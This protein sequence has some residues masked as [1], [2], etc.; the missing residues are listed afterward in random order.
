MNSGFSDSFAG[1]LN[2]T[3]LFVATGTFRVT[4]K[5]VTNAMIAA[6]ANAKPL[7]RPSLMRTLAMEVVAATPFIEI[8]F[9][10]TTS[11]RSLVTPPSVTTAV[12]ASD[13]SFTRIAV[14]LFPPAM[15]AAD[16]AAARRAASED[17]G[18]PVRTVPFARAPAA[19]AARDAESSRV[20]VAS[21]TA[22]PPDAALAAADEARAGSAAKAAADTVAV[23]FT[24]A[25]NDAKI[26]ILTRREPSAAVDT[27]GT[28]VIFDGA[29]PDVAEVIASYAAAETSRCSAAMTAISSAFAGRAKVRVTVMGAVI[30]SLKAI[31]TTEELSAEDGKAVAAAACDDL[32][33]E[34]DTC[35]DD[36]TEAGASEDPV[37]S[38]SVRD[39]LR[40]ALALSPCE[41]DERLEYDSGVAKLGSGC[42]ELEINAA[43]LPTVALADGDDVGVSVDE[44]VE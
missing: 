42:S 39:A 17:D 36:D 27:I 23:E 18:R 41:R 7:E 1:T 26:C 3:L 25:S 16:A 29:R 32:V 22:A 5:Y 30:F 20:A 10:A 19:D 21:T 4:R 13:V 34:G 35:G 37:T 15:R 24:V 8:T 2:G 9:I 12:G 43:E 11:L 31:D 14:L 40:V 28:T 6:T 33:T 38:P 44:G